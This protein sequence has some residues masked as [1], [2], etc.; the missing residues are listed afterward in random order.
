MTTN[1][2]K[3]FIVV[4]LI[5]VLLLSPVA[6]SNRMSA[7]AAVTSETTNLNPVL[8]ESLKR[9][10]SHVELINTLS[11]DT[12]AWNVNFSGHFGG[13]IYGVD[14][15]G[16]Y[17]Y[18]GEGG[19][20][21]ILN[22]A[23]PGSPVVVGRTA[24]MRDLV[25]GVTVFGDYA[26]I[27]NYTGGLRII[28]ISDPTNPVEVGFYD[29]PGYSNYVDVSGIYAYVADRD[30]LRI[31]NISNPSTPFEVG[32]ISRPAHDVVTRGN[33]AYVGA[34]FAGGF[35]IIDVSNPEMPTEV[36]YFDMD[37]WSFDVDIAV[38]G[39]YVFASSKFAYPDE[40]LT[41]Y[42]YGYLIINVSDPTNPYLVEFIEKRSSI[43]DLT[44]SGIYAYMAYSNGDLLILDIS[45]PVQPVHVGFFEDNIFGRAY[46]IAVS[47]NLTYTVH[48]FGYGWGG[49]ANC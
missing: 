38:Y 29:T 46:G 3:Y 19:C 28:D 26:Y 15:Q 6:L 37:N 9:D 2:T 41:H 32:F 31:I 13:K 45:D 11:S 4:L 33:Y 44:I 21:T 22:I 24:T 47:G 7:A 20:L 17:A 16:D 39:D 8:S 49:D 23:N 36:G 1:N 14:V 18:M 35:W 40:Y 43:E 25:Y 42:V 30:S 10:S 34:E 5:I 48:M 27:A 12:S